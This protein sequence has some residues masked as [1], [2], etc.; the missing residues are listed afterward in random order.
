MGSILYMPVIYFS[1]SAIILGL[2]ITDLIS[3]TIAVIAYTVLAIM[4]VAVQIFLAE[5]LK[6]LLGRRVMKLRGF[7]PVVKIVWAC[8]WIAFFLVEYRFYGHYINQLSLLAW[9]GV[10]ILYML[11]VTVLAERFIMEEGLV[12][13]G[14]VVKW[15]E[16]DCYEWKEGYRFMGFAFTILIKKKKTAF[17]N[18]LKISIHNDQWENVDTI[19]K[20]MGCKQAG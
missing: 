7:S 4:I 8:F 12:Y 18:E 20:Q 15:D 13:D 17:P 2:S 3:D 16:I 6:K 19:L 1:L 5:R 10:L 14:S 11:Y 9:S